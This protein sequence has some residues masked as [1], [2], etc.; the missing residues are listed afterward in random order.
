MHRFRSS[1]LLRYLVIGHHPAILFPPLFMEAELLFYLFLGLGGAYWSFVLLPQKNNIISFFKDRSLVYHL[2]LI[3]GYSTY[4]TTL[5]KRS[6]SANPS[7]DMY[8]VDNP[9]SLVVT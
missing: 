7:V 6:S 1:L 3:L 8:N 2:L 5:V 4:F 9:V